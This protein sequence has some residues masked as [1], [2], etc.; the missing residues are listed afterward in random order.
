MKNKIELFKRYLI[1]TLFFF[2]PW[3]LLVQNIVLISLTLLPPYRIKK[4]QF[5]LIK[6]GFL[7]FIVYTILNSLFNNTIGVEKENLLKI[8]PLVFIPFVFNK[9]KTK[10]IYDGLLFLF[11]GIILM[12]LYS[13][14]GVIDYQYFY[15]GKKYELTNYTKLNSILGFERP[16]L[17][18]FSALNIILS[19]FFF[20]RTKK[21]IFSIGGIL[22]LGTIFYVSARLALILSIIFLI[23][24]LL[25]EIKSKKKI[26]TLILGGLVTVVIF[27]FAFNSSIKKRFSLIQK[28]SR[29]V[30]WPGTLKELNTSKD[31]IFGNGS[32]VKTRNN[33]YSFYR[34]YDKFENIDVKN[35]F[36]K[37]NY[38]THNQFLSE[39]IRGGVLG[40]FLFIFPIIIAIKENIKKKNIINISILV[41]IVLFLLVENLLERQIG[42]YLLAIVLTITIFK[43]KLLEE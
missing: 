5:K 3:W 31:F 27:L 17:G 18:Y 14:Y 34:T 10:V 12:Q 9:L 40:L 32:L 42:V 6:K 39:L 21:W 2:L 24:I 29:T 11:I 22:S 26:V 36:V 7:L 33:L 23:T 30:I 25:N 13:I 1:N 43:N 35:R 38:N 37:K 4:E 15:E 19:Y 41:S 16:Y 8:L 20:K 28:D